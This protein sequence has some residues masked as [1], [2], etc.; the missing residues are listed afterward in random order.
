MARSKAE[1]ISEMVDAGFSDEEIRSSF[2][3][4]KQQLRPL[5][6]MEIAKGADATQLI[7][8]AAPSNLGR[9]AGVASANAPG[10]TSLALTALPGANPLQAIQATHNIQQNPRQALQPIKRVSAVQGG[11]ALTPQEVTPAMIGQTGGALL[12]MTAPSLGTGNIKPNTAFKAGFVRPSTALPGEFERANEALGQARTASRA[13]DDVKEASRL[14]KMLA[15]SGGKAKL[16]EEGK[17]AIEA[18]SDL[19]ASQLEA[20]NQAMGEMQSKIGGSFANDYAQAIKQGREMLQWKAP[21]L[22]E[23]IER[24]A[25]NYAAKTGKEFTFPAITTAVNP[26]VGALKGV[27]NVSKTAGVRNLAGVASRMAGPHANITAAGANA[28][29]KM[30]SDKPSE[31]M[32]PIEKVQMATEDQLLNFVR[33]AKKSNPDISKSELSIEVRKLIKKAGLS[34]PPKK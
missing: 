11:G 10:L 13:I 14:R 31:D 28:I 32:K 26:A 9:L 15:T 20:Y 23:A 19:T 25:A 5:S 2:S 16:A 22:V 3:P 12:E 1:I 6:A 34:V 33:Q 8:Q 7:Q 17:K 30:V 18:G 27:I 24:S 21:E 29:M 4:Q